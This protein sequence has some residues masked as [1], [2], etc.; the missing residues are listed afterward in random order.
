MGPNPNPLLIIGASV[1]HLFSKIRPGHQAKDKHQLSYHKL[2]VMVRTVIES[3]VIAHF[4]IQM[5]LACLRMVYIFYI[6]LVCF[7]ECYNVSDF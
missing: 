5:F 7:V 1:N 3:A 6:L 4:W 2:N